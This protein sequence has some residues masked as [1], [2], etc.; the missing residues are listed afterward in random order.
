MKQLL[1]QLA[2]ESAIYGISNMLTKLI[3]IF[4][5]PL[6]TRLLTPSDY[7]VLNLVN[8]TFYFII[9]LAVFALDSAAAR[10]YYDSSE[11]ED[12]KSSIASWFWFQLVS[13]GVL[14]VLI[15][16]FSSFMSEWILKE[17]HPQLFMLPA[18]GLLANI[19][20]NMVTNWLRFQRKAIHTVL[21]TLTNVLVNIG[22]N[23]MFVLVLK[24]GVKG[25]L[26]ST[27]L[28]NA[29]AS[30]YV[31]TLMFDWIQPRYFSLKRLKDMLRFSLPLIP[32]SVAFW[33]LNSSSAFVIEHY[34]NKQEVGLYSIGSMLASAVTMVVGAFQMAW[35]P[36]AY[37][38]IEKPEAKNTYAM[39]L[40]LYSMLMSCVALTVA[41]FAKEGLILL[42]SAD[43]YSAYKVAGILA[44]NAIIYGYAYIAV[45]GTSIV[46]DNKPLAIG[47]FTSACIT[48]LLYFLLVPYY[49]KEGA[50]ISAVLGYLFVPLFVFYKAQKY[51]P[52]PYKFLLS[53]FIVGVAVILFVLSFFLETNS[54]IETILIKIGLL[55][56]YVLFLL[57]MFRKNYPE[58]DLKGIGR[59]KTEL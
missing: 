13:S 58:I 16:L 4:L 57:F 29:L 21:F 45:I 7:G 3:G 1:K 8:S 9:V 35:G 53:I 55:I 20:P 6:Y 12:R 46:K 11:E 32:T 39:V 52:I 26:I 5:V 44:F 22:L 38:I 19:L 2:G 17:H 36:F 42:T 33:I 50:A 41:L 18:L 47:V 14:C 37:S 27:L 48:A 25:I 59:R 28:S 10:W 54:R 23:I 24:W 15:M 49:K 34:H 51:W 43:Y 30:L 40:T 31:L 56:F